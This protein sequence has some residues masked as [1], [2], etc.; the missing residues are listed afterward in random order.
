MKC[1]SKINQAVIKYNQVVDQ[2]FSEP[3][4]VSGV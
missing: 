4:F 1:N 2:V 3:T